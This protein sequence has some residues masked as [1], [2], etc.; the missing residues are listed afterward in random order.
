V[1]KP[2]CST[3]TCEWARVEACVQIQVCVSSRTQTGIDT[4][5]RQLLQATPQIDQ[6]EPLIDSL[7]PHLSITSSLERAS[8]PLSGIKGTN[9]SILLDSEEFREHISTRQVS[10]PKS[11]HQ[12]NKQTNQKTYNR[13]SWPARHL[14][15]NPPLIRLVTSRQRRHPSHPFFPSHRRR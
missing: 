9:N 8:L 12:T 10:S 11:I 1:Q 2:A 14:T 4:Q 6:T 3:S 5:L 13:L 7:P 15:L